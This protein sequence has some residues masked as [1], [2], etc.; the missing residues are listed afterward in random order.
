MVANPQRALKKR[1][2][3]GLL[4]VIGSASL[5]CGAY[6]TWLMTPLQFPKTAADGVALIS[7]RRFERMPEYR[8]AEYLERTTQL[9]RDLKP[10]ARKALRSQLKPSNFR[11]FFQQM[12][13]QRAL[14]LANADPQQ[15]NHML[16]EAINQW[17]RWRGHRRSRPDDIAEQ[18]RDRRQGAFRHR[19]QEHIQEG[20]SQTGALIGEYFRAIRQRRK[21]RG[22]EEPGT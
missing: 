17:G 20:N 3:I 12:M 8:K 7:S 14:K 18:E 13:I 4:I 2:L 19:M 9:M 1:I 21:E 16:D 10:E 6:F 15:R 11:Q 22:I 5:A